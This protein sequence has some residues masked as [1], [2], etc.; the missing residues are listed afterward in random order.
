MIPFVP[1]F[2]SSS[3]FFPFIT[4]KAFLFRIIVEVI[5]GAWLVLAL[6]SS[7]YRPKKSLILYVV[8][9]FIFIIGLANLFGVEP[10]KS[11]WSNYERM[12]GFV[13]LLH[14]GALFLVMG[15]IFEDKEW[16]WWWNTSLVASLL[17]VFYAIFQLLGVFEIH[18]GGARVDGT[19]GNAAYLALYLLIHIFVALYYLVKSKS[20]ELRWAY[21]ALIVLQTS[22]LYFT[23]TRGAILGLLGG[24]FIIALLNLRNKEDVWA[25]KMSQRALIALVLFVGVFYMARGTEFVTSSP[26]LSRF[27]NLSISTLKTEGRAFIWPMAIEGIKERP[28]LGWGQENFNYVFAEHYQAEMFRLEPWFDRAHNI[29]LDWGIAGGL[30][31]LGAYLSLY[32]VFLFVL[33]K[34]ESNLSYVEKSVLTGLLSAYF[35]NNFFVFDNLL[36]YILFF[37]LL[38]YVHSKVSVDWSRAN[39]LFDRMNSK[40]SLSVVVAGVVLIVYLVNVK[41]IIANTSLINALQAVQGGASK[42]VAISNFKKAYESS[43]LGRPETVEWVSSSAPTILSDE[44]IPMEERNAYF[45]FAKNVLE[46]INQELSGDPRYEI[47]SGNFY[48]NV[49]S[50]EDARKHLLLARDLMP[51]KQVIHFSLGQLAFQENKSAEALEHLKTAYE[52]APDY[53][54]AK[55]IYLIGAIYAKDYSIVDELLSSIDPESLFAD[56]RVFSAMFQSGQKSLLLATLQSLKNKLPEKKELIDEYIRQVNES[57]F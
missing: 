39:S 38:A 25:K 54:E 36:S 15:S 18:Q 20:T 49:G 14:F 43:R 30:L 24:F 10:V 41:P 29:F 16:R 50:V 28:L 37:S 34:K 55:I 21:V 8:G 26:V 13:S 9:A 4:T 47:V 19:I 3:F 11:F 27:S 44:S 42:S 57:N 2:V 12:E 32:G 6:T 1:F 35:F 56:E 51:E 31:G 53:N 23:A 40:A 5:F 46:K 52:L 45:E 7:E 17:M 48:S 33:W 22:I